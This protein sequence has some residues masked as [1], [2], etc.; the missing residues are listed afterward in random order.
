MKYISTT[1]IANMFNLNKGTVINRFKKLDIDPVEVN[2]RYYYS[3]EDVKHFEKAK[4][5][6]NLITP[7]ERFSIIEYF[8]SHRINSSLDLTKVFFIPQHRID[9]I[10]SEYLNSNN[11][12]TISSK[13]NKIL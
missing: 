4:P 8:L 5:T 9:R 6:Y 1:E 7:N 13:M 11:C 2:R 12:V 3:T 10:I